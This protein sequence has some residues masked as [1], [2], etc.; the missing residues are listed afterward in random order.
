MPAKRQALGRGLDALFSPAGERPAR[1]EGVRQV[2][3]ERIIPNP[4]QPRT[5]MDDDKLAELAASIKIH[6]LIQ[7]IIVTETVEGFVL[8]AGERRWRASRLAGLEQVPVVIKETTPQDMLELALIENVQRADLNALEEAYA[9]RQ[10]L[11]EFGLTQEAVAERV[12]KARS[13]VANLVRLLTLPEAI[14]AAVND[15]RLSGAH[16]RALL[17]LPSPDMQ[18]AAMN[19]VK[20]LGLSV[21]QTETLVTNL[22]ADKKP[23][24]RQRRQLPP[25]LVDIQGQFEAALGTRVNIEKG[26]KGGRV[27]I[28]FYSDE[29]LNAIYESIVGE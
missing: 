11:D 3:I 18:I 16:A 28:H 24:A 15:G 10:L 4:R 27:V 6:G 1:E 14:Q 5:V 8:I 13:T 29:D 26:D 12:G 19:Q 23:P 7:P 20:K 9:Y 21:R 22:M 2:A 17:P 25:E